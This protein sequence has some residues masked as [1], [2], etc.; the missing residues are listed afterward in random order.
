MTFNTLTKQQKEVIEN[1]G[2][3]RPFSGEYDD[4]YLPGTF[5]CRKC[6][7]PLFSSK[8]KFDAGCG[9]PAFDANFSNAIKRIKG[10]FT[11]WS[12]IRCANCDGHLGHVFEGEQFTIK[13]TRHCVNSASIKFI[14]Q[15]DDLPRVIKKYNMN[16][17][18]TYP[19]QLAKN[20]IKA[21]KTLKDLKV[22]DGDIVLVNNKN[23]AAY[24]KSESEFILLSPICTH[25][26]CQVRW[27]SIDYVW[28]CPCHGSK[29]DIN[30]NVLNGPAKKPMKKIILNKNE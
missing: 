1:R 15:E 21:T 22:G 20:F 14:R 9:W 25:A 5:I 26:K 24:K 3:E 16:K 6:N 27:N 12:E 4:F 7:N 17:L 11:P 30:G 13:N 28:D 10:P 8:A 2:T 23:Y 19:T 18:L 29:F